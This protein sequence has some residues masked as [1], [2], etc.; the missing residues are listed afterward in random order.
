MAIR[1]ERQ[2]ILKQNQG[3]DEDLTT[4][5]GI[6]E[7]EAEE[8]PRREEFGEEVGLSRLGE[9]LFCVDIAAFEGRHLLLVAIGPA[10][11]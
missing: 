7:L 9:F 6:G 2:Q 3:L 5:C 11:A 10:R 4:E 8:V 1:N